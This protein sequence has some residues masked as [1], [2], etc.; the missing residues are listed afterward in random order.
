MQLW[1]DYKPNYTNMPST[2]SITAA[3]PL[4]APPSIL[5]DTCGGIHYTP[6]YLRKFMPIPGT[7]YDYLNLTES[8]ITFTPEQQKLINEKYAK[9]MDAGVKL[10][11]E[12]KANSTEALRYNVGK[13][14]WSLIPME[15]LEDVVKALEFGK[16]KYSANNWRKGAGL[17][18][19]ETCNS[20]RRH[21]YAWL[22]GEEL[23]PE[24]GIS[25]L[26]H[27]GCNVI[28]LLYFAKNKTKM[29]RDDRA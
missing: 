7:E 1:P 15:A 12:V 22:R 25:H 14:D 27:I 13:L 4:Q 23:D 24:S 26:G 29:T 11:G 2:G 8:R 21:L 10:H 16:Q 5:S 20:L 3:K 6:D 18:W 17:S 19:L 9:V 28:F